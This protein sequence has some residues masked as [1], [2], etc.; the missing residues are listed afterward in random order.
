M[1]VPFV[2]F[3]HRDLKVVYLYK[4]HDFLKIIT[5][6]MKDIFFMRF[7][8]S[9]ASQQDLSKYTYLIF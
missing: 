6:A 3:Q 9:F 4:N 1:N 7:L 8:T 5:Q 2:T